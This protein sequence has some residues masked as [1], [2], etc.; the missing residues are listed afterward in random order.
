MQ[1]YLILCGLIFGVITLLY[2]RYRLSGYSKISKHSFFLVHTGLFL[3]DGSKLI[4][5]IFQK[6]LWLYL[7][8][9]IY[10]TLSG[11]PGYGKIFINLYL[12][13][14]KNVTDT[15]IDILFV[16]E[17][18]IFCTEAKDYS[19]YILGREN[20][21]NWMQMFGKRNKYPFHNPIH[22]NYSH[23]KS[24]ENIIPEY[25]KKI[26]P[27]VVFSNKSKLN[28]D[29][30]N[31]TVIQSREVKKWFKNRWEKILSKD[32]IDKIALILEKYSTITPE[33]ESEHQKEVQLLQST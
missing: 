30:P 24:L 11:I 5:Y 26:I 21:Q 17:S 23:T 12:P 3:D 10:N 28:I 25:K 31:N 18:G 15:E 14:W 33:Q 9:S 4:R 32:E 8:Y 20:D 13:Q 19:G 7:E 22:Q 2:V 6:Y 27:I 16:H 29:C 1:I